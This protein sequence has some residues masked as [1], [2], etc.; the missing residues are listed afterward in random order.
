MEN[1]DKLGYICALQNGNNLYTLGAT[2]ELDKQENYM[3]L[4]D[5]C[6]DITTSLDTRQVKQNTPRWFE[7]RKE[8]KVTGSTMHRALGLDTLKSQQSHF[9]QVYSGVTPK[10]KKQQCSM[11]V[12]IK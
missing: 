2:V 6:L 4:I 12:K 5:K 3:C 8:A 1:I 9:D 10:S 11:G 7:I